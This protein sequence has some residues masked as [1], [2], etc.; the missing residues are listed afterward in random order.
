MARDAT[1]LPNTFSTEVVQNLVYKI[2]G[3][4]ADLDHERGVYM[5]RCRDIRDRIVATY[6]EAKARGIPHKELRKFVTARM[7]LEAARKV[8]ADLE[9]DQRETVQMLA[10]A[11]GDAADLPL[12]EHRMSMAQAAAQPAQATTQQ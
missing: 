11:F 1:D 5:K 7:K 3:Y 12:F 9:A 6:D 10:E 4:F 2:E 8:L